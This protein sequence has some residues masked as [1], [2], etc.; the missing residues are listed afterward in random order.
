MH[1]FF[2]DTE[3]RSIFNSNKTK[4]KLQAGKYCFFKPSPF[5]PQSQLRPKLLTSSWY[6]AR[7]T[8]LTTP[9]SIPI[10]SESTTNPKSHASIFLQKRDKRSYR[11]DAALKGPK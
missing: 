4:I 9:R 11:P 3:T 1:T 5:T 6:P 7:P 2:T 8:L 10:S